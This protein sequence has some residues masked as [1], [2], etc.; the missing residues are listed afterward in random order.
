FIATA[1]SAIVGSAS[2]GVAS[3][4][5][6]YEAALGIGIASG[7]LLGGLLGEVSWRGPFFGV[8]ALMAIAFIVTMVLLPN[9]RQPT[10]RSSILD[11]FRALR[12]RS[13]LTIGITALCYNFGFFA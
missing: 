2:G 7:P 6:L 8:A 3:A 5:I 13:L 4:I 11:P 9:T 12:H 1:L 10:K